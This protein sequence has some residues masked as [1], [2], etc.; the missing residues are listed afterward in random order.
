[1]LKVGDIWYWYAFFTLSSFESLYQRA[2]SGLARIRPT[3][4]H[5]S[6]STATPRATL[7]SGVTKVRSSRRQHLATLD[8]TA[9]SSVQRSSTTSQL[10]SMSCGCILTV[11]TTKRPKSVSRRVIQYV[12]SIRICA[13]KN[14]LATRAVTLVSMLMMMGRHTS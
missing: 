2:S 7:S 12:A 13:V 14:P 6:I 8:Q 3:A 10:K 1:M 11:E 9:S 4:A 5:L